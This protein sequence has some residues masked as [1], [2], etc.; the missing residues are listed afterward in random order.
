MA[1]KLTYL[2][3]TFHLLLYKQMGACRA[4]STE[5][6][7]ELLAHTVWGQSRD[8]VATVFSMSDP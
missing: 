3:D 8:H 5:S 7:S 1:E 2:A 6:A 4:K